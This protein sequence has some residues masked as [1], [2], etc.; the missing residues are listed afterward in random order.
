MPR[1]SDVVM[2]H[3]QE[4]LHRGRLVESTHLGTVGVPG[5]GAFFV[6]QLRVVEQVVDAAAFE[7]NAC[8]VT[9][10]CGSILTTWVLGKTLKECRS[11]TWQQL[12]QQAD[13]LPPDK[14]H[15]AVT[16]VQAL[17]QA[18]QE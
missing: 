5:Q 1:F 2:E 10:A 11:L 4:P 15:C 9:I 13:G 17:Q 18:L 14:R 16:A 6:L 12:E 7:C 8:G 3:F